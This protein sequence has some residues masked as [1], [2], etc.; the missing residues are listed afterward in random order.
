[1]PYNALFPQNIVTIITKTPSGFNV[2]LLVYLEIFRVA[3][4]VAVVIGIMVLAVGFAI[5]ARE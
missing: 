2:N 3:T 4:S 1:M 5:L